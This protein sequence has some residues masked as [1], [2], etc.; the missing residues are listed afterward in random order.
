MNVNSRRYPL[1]FTLPALVLY[2]AF[3]IIPSAAGIGYAFTDWSAFSQQVNFIGW[4]NF[5]QIFSPHEKYLT[6]I[7]NTLTFT[8]ITVVLKTV[9]ALGLALLLNEGVRRFVNFYR[10]MIYLPA[11]LPMLV[12]GLIF[13][14]ILNPASGILNSFLR[15]IGLP[16]FA[17]K[18]LGDPH[19]ALYSI[20]GV[21]TWKGVGYI[22]VI[23]LAGLQTIPKDYYEAAQI[24]GAN[25]WQRSGT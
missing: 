8:A 22:M 5:Q 17:L 6:Y 25:A 10:V 4:Q 15:G 21:D 24:D 18:W 14:S 1:Y 11:I 16:Q 19:I 13:R 2:V 12:V 23:L 7:S 3:F 20:I 9:F